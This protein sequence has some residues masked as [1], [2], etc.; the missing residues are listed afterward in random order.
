VYNNRL[1]A[2]ALAAQGYPAPLAE[3]PD[4]HNYTAWRDALDPHLTRLLK[5]LWGP[6]AAE[7]AESSREGLSETRSRAGFRREA[8]T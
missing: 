8:Q 6:P 4:L 7:R 3:V 5:D 1:M 2:S